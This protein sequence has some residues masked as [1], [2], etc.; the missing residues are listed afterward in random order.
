[1]FVVFSYLC[2]VCD[3]EFQDNEGMCHFVSQHCFWI[4]AY[5]G[6]HTSHF[7]CRVVVAGHRGGEEGPGS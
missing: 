7:R 6:Y 1:M 4:V 3:G 2:V 5:Y